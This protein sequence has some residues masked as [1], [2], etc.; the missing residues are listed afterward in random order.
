MTSVATPLPVSTSIRAIL[1]SVGHGQIGR[2]VHASLTLADPA[3]LRFS[4]LCATRVPI[5]WS[6]FGRSVTAT[7]Q[8]NPSFTLSHSGRKVTAS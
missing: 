2:I 8:A 6:M 5:R 1:G 4:L 7:L 3:E